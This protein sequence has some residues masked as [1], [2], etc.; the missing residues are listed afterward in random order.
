[1]ADVAGAGAGPK[2]PHR[3]RLRVR[4]GDRGAARPGAPVF[5]L[6]PITARA[7]AGQRLVDLYP[8]HRVDAV[9]EVLDLDGDDVLA[10]DARDRRLPARRGRARGQGAPRSRAEGDRPLRGLPAARPRHL[11]GLVRRA[12]APRAD[13]PVGLR[14][15]GALSRRAAR[16]SLVSGPG[17]SDRRAARPAPA[18]RRWPARRRRDRCQDGRLRRRPGPQPRHELRL[19]Q[20]FDLGVQDAGHPPPPEIE[21]ELAAGGSQCA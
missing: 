3:W 9:L 2:V 15:P 13:R 18:G 14:P 17:A 12:P 21:Q 11:R 1:M 8:Q 6:G 20:R 16:A 19:D 7:E 10:C 4:R 5:Q